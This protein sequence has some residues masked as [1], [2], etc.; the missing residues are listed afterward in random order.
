M[1]KSVLLLL[2]LFVTVLVIMLAL[3]TGSV[4]ISA[5]QL[6]HG[7]WSSDNSLQHSIVWELRWPRTL[8]AFVTGGLLALSGCLM[9]VLLRNPLADPY[10][11]GISG[12]SSVAVLLAMMAG[13]GGS[14]LTGSA[15]SGA[16][17]SMLL[18]F[19][20]ARGRGSWTPT[21][22]LLTGIVIA[23]GWSALISFLLAISPERQL[24]GMLF[25]LMGDLGHSR[26]GWQDIAVLLA[27]LVLALIV[28]RALNLLSRGE[29]VA[30]S[31]G[32]EV[33]RLRWLLYVMAS[34][35]TASAVSLAGTV[36][37]VGLV[38]PHMLRLLSGSDH[39]VLLPASILLGGSFL[40]LADTVARTVLRGN[41]R[42][43][44]SRH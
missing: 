34:V 3:L 37:F 9:Q 19:G 39:R 30:A 27:G 42:S 15:L 2:L 24:R 20:L 38:V 18:V 5:G 44:S 14:W 28:A 17:L 31:L 4:T 16:L 33:V 40:V 26:T 6:W 10:V 11:L 23:S 35:M 21:R 41:Y 13:V 7:I 36:G 1:K 29:L 43:V 25:W 8:A 32:V 22:L 12:G